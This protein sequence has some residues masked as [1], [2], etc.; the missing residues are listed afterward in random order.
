MSLLNIDTEDGERSM[1]EVKA[2]DAQVDSGSTSAMLQ[3][4]AS[5]EGDRYGANTSP[6][7]I[8]VRNGELAQPRNWSTPPLARSYL[9]A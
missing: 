1:K 4:V 8:V 9:P 7:Q 2:A 3:Q 6:H 5:L